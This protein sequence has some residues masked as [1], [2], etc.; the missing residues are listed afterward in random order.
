M[1]YRIC[2]LLSLLLLFQSCINGN[3]CN[4]IKISETL[5][6][7]VNN[8]NIKYCSFLK[9]AL[10]GN[11]KSIKEFLLLDIQDSAGYDHGNVI[12]KLIKKLGDDVVIKSVADVTSKEKKRIL[13]YINVGFEYGDFTD[14][15][16]KNSYPALYEFLTKSKEKG[17]PPRE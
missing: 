8:K 6:N 17:I 10:G 2:F 4:D 16:L 14:Q 3:K 15:D 11:E 9:K 1:R 7:H 13:S 5:Q 12:L